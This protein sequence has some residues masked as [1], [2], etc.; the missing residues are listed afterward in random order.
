MTKRE[1]LFSRFIRIATELSIESFNSVKM[2]LATAGNPY[3]AVDSFSRL[4]VQVIRHGNSQPGYD[5][6]VQSDIFN[7]IMSVVVLVLVHMQEVNPNDFDQKPF[8][9]LFSSILNDLKPLE[10]ESVA[11]YRKSLSSM[12]E[13]FHALRP[14]V[15]PSFAFSWIQLVSHRNFL[16]SLLL[17][18]G[19]KV[20]LFILQLISMI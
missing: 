15:V 17:V 2:S 10:V 20:I 14:S 18:E 4:T 19:Q 9:R 16:S 12:S 5:E 6:I 1:T 8:L 3:Q 11:V 13:M 7:S